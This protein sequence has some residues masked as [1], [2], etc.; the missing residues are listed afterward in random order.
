VRASRFEKVEMVADEPINA[1][2][3]G[4]EKLAREEQRAGSRVRPLSARGVGA[5]GEGG[6]HVCLRPRAYR[7]GR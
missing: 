2:A 6:D 1:A 4:R 7:A 5:A 3:L